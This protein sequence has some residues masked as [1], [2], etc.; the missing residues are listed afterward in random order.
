ME[1]VTIVR[2]GP[3]AEAFRIDHARFQRLQ[4]A[5]KGRLARLTGEADEKEAQYGKEIRELEKRAKTTESGLKYVVLREGAGDKPRPGQT[6][7]AHYTGRFMDGRVFDT[8]RER[9]PFSFPVGKGRVIRGWDEALLDMRVGEKRALILPPGLAYGRE[10]AGEGV[11]PPN[12]TLFFEV[13]RLK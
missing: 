8:S 2:V 10:G 12:A 7:Q 13:E 9:G 4:A 6:I 1:K 11:I 3:A 5:N